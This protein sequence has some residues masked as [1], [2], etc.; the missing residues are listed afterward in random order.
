MK[1]QRKE[2]ANKNIIIK[3]TE[4][5]HRFLADCLDDVL[6]RELELGNGQDF[7]NYGDGKARKYLPKII[8]K[9]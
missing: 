6:H 3:L 7:E 1:I 2:K 4:E 5:E 8:D 9:L